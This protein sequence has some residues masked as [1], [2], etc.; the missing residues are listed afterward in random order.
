MEQNGVTRRQA[1][2]ISNANPADNAS[3]ESEET[4]VQFTVI[5][6][7]GAGGDIPDHDVVVEIIAF[8]DHKLYEVRRMITKQLGMQDTSVLAFSYGPGQNHLDISLTLQQ[9]E[10]CDGHILHLNRRK[11]NKKRAARDSSIGDATTIHVTCTTRIGT[12]AEEQPRRIKVYVSPQDTCR[13]MFQEVSSVWQKS[14]LKFKCGRVV[15]K[16]ERSFAEQGVECG[17]EIVV[18]G[19]RG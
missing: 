7:E 2:E 14:G 13:E 5:V 19:G 16:E 11:T 6:A 10:I 17:S 4:K 9:L 8:V 3:E 12:Q 18:T 15:L 1:A